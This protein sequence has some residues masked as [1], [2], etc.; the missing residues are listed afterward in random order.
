V[1]LSFFGCTGLKK[2]HAGGG[3]DDESIRVC[4]I[5]LSD[6]PAYLDRRR[7]EGAVVDLKVYTA[8]FYAPQLID[9][10]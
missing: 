7:G 6:V 2:V 9:G 5:P 3:V 8:L 10:H 4:E 1:L